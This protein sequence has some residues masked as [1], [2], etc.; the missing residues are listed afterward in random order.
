[1]SEM[2]RFRPEMP[3]EASRASVLAP[4]DAGD[5]VAE[6]YLYDP[7]DSWGGWWGVSAKEFAEALA[8]LPEGTGEIRLHINS[9]GGEVWDAMAIV[10]QLRR[11]EA[12]VVAVVDGIAASAASMIAAAADEMVMGVGAQLMIHDA[13][14]V[15]VGNEADLLAAARR[16]GSDSDSIARIYAHKGGGDVAEWR[17]LMRAET[18]FYGAEAVAAGLADS[19]VEGGEATTSAAVLPLFR[20]RGRAEAPAPRIP[21]RSAAHL[22]PPTAE[23]AGS[24]T[25]REEDAMASD[26]F[27]AG[28]RD[29]LGITDAGIG[30]DGLLAALDE[31]L[32]EQATTPEGVQMIDGA[33]LDVLRSDAAAGRQALAAQTEQRRGT[34]VDAAIN[35]GRIAPARRQHWLDALAADET[36]A[37]EALAGLA[38]GL[39]PV[40]EIGHSDGV[41]S[42]EDALYNQLY[43][44]AV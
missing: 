28:L 25:N 17:D 12:R 40:E 15:A 27:M 13:W 42:A 32:A 29:R 8:S 44:K 19:S 1:M 21:G 23:P 4:E 34:L 35:D 37:A 10:N 2:F 14:L 30:E 6:L 3:T 36:G 38:K 39:I 5:G 33:T 26:N 24:T 11:H 18:W 20:Y 43:P 31:A 16:A 9:P 22:R 7:I 41:D